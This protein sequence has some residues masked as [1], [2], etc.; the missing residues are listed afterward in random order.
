MLNSV[1]YLNYNKLVAKKLIDFDSIFTFP[2]LEVKIIIHEST[3]S[4]GWRT[5][6]D[7]KQIEILKK[8]ISSQ[9]HKVTK[10]HEAYSIDFIYFS[11]KSESSMCIFVF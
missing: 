1:E 2:T 10:V 7:M 8:V 4:F 11:E 6:N 5:K 9:S 3:S